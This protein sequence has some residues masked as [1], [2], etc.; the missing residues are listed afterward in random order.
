[1]QLAAAYIAVIL[2]WS[3]TP[4]GIVWSSASVSPTLALLMRMVIALVLGLAVIKL[5]KITFP[6]HKQAVRLYSFSAIG[7]AGGMFFTYLSAQS[8]PSGLISLI[9]GLAPLLSGLYSQKLIKEKPFT[10]EKKFALVIAFL[11]LLIVCFDNLLHMPNNLIGLL[12]VFIAVNLFSVSGVLVKSVVIKIHPIA[13]TVGTLTITLPFFV[14]TW[15]VLDG[16]FVMPDWQ[17]KALWS[18]IYLGVFGSLLGFIAYFY[19]L[20]RLSA[21]TVSLVTLMTP[22][23]AIMLGH[24]FNG[25]MISQSLIFGSALVLLGLFLYCFGHLGVYAFRVNTLK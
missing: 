10:L 18:I 2:I 24:Q 1:M 6:W 15:L 19:V 7:I 12:Y 21:S 20:Q 8:V 13:S 17:P 11:G 3:T 14:I 5:A 9:F 25:E 23:I 16:N 4:L 22:I